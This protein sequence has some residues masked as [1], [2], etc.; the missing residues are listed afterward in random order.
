MSFSPRCRRITIE[1]LDIVHDLAMQIWPKCYRRAIAP[2]QIDELASAL[3]DLDRLEDAM[4]GGES[5]WVVRVG[6]YDVGFI[7]AR[8]DGAYIRIS[9]LYVL[10]D[11]RGFGLGKLLVQAAQGHFGP[12]QHLAVLVNKDHETSVDFCLRAGFAID[13]EIATQVGQYGFTHYVMRKPLDA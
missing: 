4:D 9:R 5:F 1:D 13:R 3:F 2:T 7:S 6:E 10:P 8:L 12:A 11:Y